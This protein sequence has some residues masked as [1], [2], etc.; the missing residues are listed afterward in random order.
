MLSAT[1]AERGQATVEWVG[2]VVIV[3]LAL[4]VLAALAGAALPG[5][6]LARAVGSRIVCAVAGGCDPGESGLVGA[7]G[8]ELAGLIAEHAPTIAYEEGMR[9]LPIDYR[10]CREDPC[11][12]GPETGAVAASETGE[13]VTLFAH[14][15]D[16]RAGAEPLAGVESPDCSG[17]RAGSLYLQ[18]WAYYPGSDTK[19]Y[20]DAGDHADDWESL[21]LRISP[22]GEDARASS[23][24]GYNY[25]G[26]P[27]NWL[28]DAGIAGHDGWGPDQGLY[29]VS[30]GSHAGHVV[31]DDAPT[32]WTPG[33]AARVVA[34]D[35]IA[36]A[37][38]D[39]AFAI[40]PPWRK[41]VWTD[42]EYGGTD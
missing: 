38:P 2:L 17:S 12:L 10:G 14:P 15:V 41:H 42:P 34:L 30:G 31:D 7:Y 24:R 19:L 1:R 35:P 4:A 40:T 29:F 8:D 36:A 37:H 6:A 9:A 11:S 20:G 3:A 16:C 5:I 39:T 25:G 22:A 21:Q 32:R 18:Y 33:D 28:S 27:G 13:P 26:G 23:H